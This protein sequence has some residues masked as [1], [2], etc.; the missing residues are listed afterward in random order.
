M[1]KSL[2]VTSFA[3][4]TPRRADHLVPNGQATL[5]LDC[6]LEHG[7]LESWR[8]P[9]LTLTVPASTK[10]TYQAFNCCWL[11]S[12]TC[13]SFAEGSPELRHVFATQYN[14]VPYPVRI[15]FD[16][17]CN[18]QIKRLGLPCPS[19]APSVQAAQVNSK[20]AGPRSYAYQ[21]EDSF[22]NRSALSMG[23]DVVVVEDG[24]VVMVSGWMVPQDGWDI[25][26]V[27]LYRSTPGFDSPVKEGQ[28]TVDAAWMEVAELDATATSYSDTKWNVDLIDALRE[29]LVM[30]PPAD[31]Q[32]ITWVKSMNCLAG[33][34]G[35]TLYFSVN[36][37]YHNWHISMQLDDTIKAI[38]ESNDVVYVAT[39]GAPYIVKGAVDSKSAASRSVLRMPESLPIVGA[40][41]RS[42]IAIPSGAVYPSHSGLVV[43]SGGSA[44]KILTTNHYGP[45]D[46]QQLHPDTAVI[47]YHEGRLYAFFRNGGF[48]MVMKDGAGTGTELDHH[49]ELSMRP[50]E[51]FTTR[52]GRL[53]MRV[54]TDVL[55]WNR[56]TGLMPHRYEGAEVLSGVPV[57]FGA[58]Q[59]IM[60]P[61]LSERVQI[62][63]DTDEALNEEAFKT[64]DWAMPLW[65]TGQ[66]FR[67]VLTG[68]G[69]V[70]AFTLAPSSK[71]L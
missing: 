64:E 62:Y 50:N 35:R 61:G 14:E 51:V 37:E 8:N 5:A 45:E 42:L 24:E 11:G 60:K 48:C 49:T 18:P 27:V 15:T 4:S 29:D 59:L 3:G 53:F 2:G 21:F 63:V 46:W 54:G 25:A 69:T 30:P 66:V 19:N 36:N 32:G 12:A 7:T 68:V 67:W 33:F 70:K 44:P 20:G 9:R 55:E 22:G 17:L 26:K 10:T 58:A 41:H 1:A 28:N 65:A 13:A 40:A 16:E 38:V 23:S 56:G 34:V 6:R 47:G 31:L 52:S 39:D 71:E 43:M 57:N